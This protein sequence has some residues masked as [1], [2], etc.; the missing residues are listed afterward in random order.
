[1]ALAEFA[2]VAFQV[3]GVPAHEERESSNYVEGRYFCSIGQDPE[4]EI[5]YADDARLSVFRFWLPILGDSASSEQYAVRSSAL[6]AE[7]GY[8]CFVPTPSWAYKNWDGRG[9]YFTA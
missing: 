9:S 7:S 3:L 8:T 6:L 2:L 5:C 4:L 1:M